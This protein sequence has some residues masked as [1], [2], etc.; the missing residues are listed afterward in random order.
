MGVNLMV[1]KSLKDL[2]ITSGGNI[3]EYNDGLPHVVTA[4]S[5]L[6]KNADEWITYIS[7]VTGWS[8]RDN[9]ANEMNAFSVAAG[10]TFKVTN[11]ELAQMLGY[12]YNTTYTES[13]SLI[14]A[15]E[16]GYSRL[17]IQG[18]AHSDGKNYSMLG[19]FSEK[20]V[21]FSNET[22]I[23]RGFNPY[24]TYD[25][26]DDKNAFLVKS[27]WLDSDKKQ[28]VKDFLDYNCSGE[29][30]LCN[31][32][33]VWKVDDTLDMVV[34]MGDY[35]GIAAQEVNKNYVEFSIGVMEAV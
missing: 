1:I 29:A 22:T 20:P 14:E 5:D 17:I 12:A 25:K 35:S 31:I 27:V 34:N 30:E 18:A 33:G 7:S 21:D 15:V 13:S 26:E 32:Y 24:S 8:V 3:F 4:P 11:E 2:T 9:E 28:Y 6:T 23:L 19:D 10:D 16:W